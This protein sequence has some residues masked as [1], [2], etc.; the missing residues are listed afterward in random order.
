MINKILEYL[1]NRL[2]MTFIG[3][4]T[5][6]AIKYDDFIPMAKWFEDNIVLT[7]GATRGSFRIETAPHTRFIL[8]LADRAEITHMTLKWASQTT[9]T[10][11]GFG[12]IMKYIHTTYDNAFVMFPVANNLK[13]LIAF[14][15]KPLLNGCP[16]VKTMIDDYKQ[17]ESERK[18]SFLYKTGQN[19]LAILSPSNTKSITVRWK[20]Y[21]ECS[22]MDMTVIKEA[23]ERSKTYTSIGHKSIRTSTQIHE[24]DSINQSFNSSEAKYQYFMY[25]AG[26]E[27]HFYPKRDHLKYPSLEEYK[28]FKNKNNDDIPTYEILSDYK[29]YAAKRATLQCPLCDHQITDQERVISILNNKL[30]WVQVEATQNTDEGVFYKEAN[31][32]KKSF[33][34]V[35][36]DINTFCIHNVPLSEIASQEI[37]CKYAEPHLR[38][39]L[40]KKLYVGYYNQIYTPKTNEKTTKND[41]LLLSNGLKSG[42]VPQDTIS[43]HLGVDL[44]KNRLYYVLGAV[45]HRAIISIVEHGELFSEDMG[46]DFIELENIIQSSYFTKDG[47]EFK[48]KSVGIDIRGFGGEAIEGTLI[49]RRAETWNFIQNYIEKLEDLGVLNSDSFIFPTMGFS[50]LPKEQAYRETLRAYTKSDLDSS[51]N[52]RKLKVLD[53]SNMQIKARLFNMLERSI[54][55][56]KE[57]KKYNRELFFINQDIVLDAEA[58]S[59]LPPHERMTKHSFEAHMTSEHLTYKIKNGKPAKVQTYEKKYDSVRNDYLDCVCSVLV[60]MMY[61]GADKQH[62]V[63]VVSDE[64][65]HNFDTLRGAFK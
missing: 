47:R 2:S 21:D 59:T 24:N 33:N 12:M 10:T 5:L 52:K 14:K 62:V 50:T 27:E 29:P 18:N 36:T 15:V 64:K 48:I 1:Q 30:K 65:I 28:I 19:I 58:R 31:T 42:V 11:V 25:C 53:F 51:I 43:L 16:A 3:D 4:K 23:D 35:G 37:E 34:S 13:T 60:Q 6:K 56:A 55:N 7:D 61:F 54:K 41:I 8:D 22:E 17:E 26:C 46:L 44:Q 32:I 39:D 57:D 9:K 63:S 40:Y 45:Q 20:L 38:D 49:S